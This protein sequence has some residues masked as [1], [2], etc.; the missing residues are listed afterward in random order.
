MIWIWVIAATLAA[1]EAFL[2]TPFKR[3]LGDLTATTTKSFAVISSKHI[4]DHWKEKVLPRYAGRIFKS[5]IVLFLCL[6]ALA[7]P[8]IVFHF[9]AGF[10]SEDLLAAMTSWEGL[11]LSLVAAT[12][13]VYVRSLFCNDKDPYSAPQ[14]ILHYGVLSSPVLKEALFDLEVSRVGRADPSI[15]DGRH[16]FVSGL[17][18]AGTTML[19]RSLYDTRQFGS[20]TYA[21]MPFVMAPG[22]WRRLRGDVR[23]GELHERAHGDGVLVDNESPEALDEV[24]WQTFARRDYVGDDHL[25]PHRLS[26][27]VRSKFQDYVGVILKHTGKHRYLSKN[28][29]NVLR[30]DGLCDAFPHAIVLVPFRAPL[31]HAF[32]LLNQH[33]LFSERQ[34]SERFTRRYM[35]WL[36]HYEFGLD[37]RRMVFG[38]VDFRH[39]DPMALD[40]W[41]EQWLDV[42]RHL[43]DLAKANPRQITLVSYE[44]LCEE[45]Q[46][47]WPR[48]CERLDLPDGPIPNY[49]A[50]VSDTPPATDDGALHDH[51]EALYRG[52]T[53]VCQANLSQV[54]LKKQ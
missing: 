25:K 5:S 15:R 39:H 37:H 48:L 30:I 17:A 52:L 45:S 9:L 20:L 51:A 18:R 47:M 27:D 31:Q 50:R 12:L 46:T 29:N 35:G 41:L 14:K 10:F 21:D 43:L 19:M 26:D 23:K 40:Y 3:A 1:V 32:S 42:Y 53:Q 24:F 4:S 8:V 36:G 22:L 34:R 2:R 13:Y 49:R 11:G 38:H 54:A 7:A 33:R 28:N 6:L 44:L 16:V